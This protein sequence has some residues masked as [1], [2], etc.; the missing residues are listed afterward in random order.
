M[1]YCF[2]KEGRDTG[3]EVTV[4]AWEERDLGAAIRIW[5]RVV[6]DGV[7]FPQRDY[8]TEESGR[9]FFGEQSFTGIARTAAGSVV[10]LYILHPNNVGRCGH[11][12]NASYAVAA[13]YRGQHIGEA[14]VR[15]SMEKGRA[16]GFRIL[17]F[18]AVVASN[19]PALA[20]YQKLGF[21]PLGRI[22]GGFQLKNGRYED[23]IPHYH[24][25]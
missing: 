2:V 20:L 9:K 5:N 12:C 16:L 22:P 19:A 24:L 21:L 11:I 14:L 3:V 4:G 7:A 23:I 18:N 15:H 10:G 8:L 25:L 1:L 6:E 13:E 17:Q